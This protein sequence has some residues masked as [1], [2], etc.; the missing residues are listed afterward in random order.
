MKP[1]FQFAVSLIRIKESL[2]DKK[3][4]SINIPGWPCLLTTKGSIVGQV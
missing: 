1:Y 3:P 4:K 2:E